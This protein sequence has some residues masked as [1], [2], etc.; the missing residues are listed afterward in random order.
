VD[1]WLSLEA[2]YSKDFEDLV[3]SKGNIWIPSKKIG[4]FCRL[5]HVLARQVNH[6]CKLMWH[7]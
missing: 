3:P 5:I 6:K 7:G 2:F 4:R 1:A